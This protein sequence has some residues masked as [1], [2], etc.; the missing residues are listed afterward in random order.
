MQLWHGSQ[1]WMGFDPWPGNSH[2]LWVQTKKKKGGGEI[3]FMDMKE[4]KKGSLAAAHTG[5]ILPEG[6][7]IGKE[8]SKGGKTSLVLNVY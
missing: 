3:N 2:M 5:E 1:L 7:Y 6:Q 4:E 8:A